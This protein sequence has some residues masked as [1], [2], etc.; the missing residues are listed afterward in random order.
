MSTPEKYTATIK[1]KRWLTSDVFFVTL[2]LD[3][4]MQFKAG[5]FVMLDLP[6]PGE[7]PRP[8]SMANAPKKNGSGT[9]E[10]CM[11]RYETSVTA[12]YLDSLPSNSSV[13]LRGPFGFFTLRDSPRP[14]F[15]VATGVGIAPILGMMRDE[16]NK[17]T[18]RDMQLL[19]G[20]RYDTDCIF[21]DELA[22]TL[23]HCTMTLSQP[24]DAWKG[25]RGRVTE[26]L[27]ALERPEQFDFYL[28]G[29]PDMVKETRDLLLS[30]NVSAERVYFEIF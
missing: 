27:N 17:K 22:A 28:C 23:P 10:I 19:F 1:E 30:R 24:S 13:T 11:K 16:Q 15:F 18:N 25:A 7:R 2:E 29:N 12:P 26:H 5:Q 9:I 8:F 4:P 3:R 6:Q 20:V 21:M 14:V